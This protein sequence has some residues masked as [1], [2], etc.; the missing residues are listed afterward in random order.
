VELRG[1]VDVAG[2][3]VLLNQLEKRRARTSSRRPPHTLWR[4]ACAMCD[5]ERVAVDVASGGRGH[6]RGLRVG[7]DE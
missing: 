5:G 1:A 6:G 3:D 2:V 4:T 7:G